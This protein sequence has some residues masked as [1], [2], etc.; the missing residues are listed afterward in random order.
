MAISCRSTPCLPG[1]TSRRRIDRHPAMGGLVRTRLPLSG[2]RITAGDDMALQTQH[3]CA[4]QADYPASGGG[5]RPLGIL[6]AALALTAGAISL[7]INVH[8]GWQTSVVAAAIFGLSDAAKILL[9]MAAAALGG[10]NIRRRMAW[11]VAVIISVAAALSSLLQSD[12]ERLHASRTAADTANAARIDDAHTRQQLAAITE[13]LSVEVLRQLADDAGA[14]AACEEASGGCGDRC[15][16]TQSPPQR[17]SGAAWPRRTTRCLAATTRGLVGQ[18]RCK[19]QSR[20]R[21]RGCSGGAHRRRQIPRRH[22]YQPRALHRDAHCSAAIGQSQRRCGNA[23]A[24]AGENA[25][26][27]G[28]ARAEFDH[29]Y[30]QAAEVGREPCL[31]SGAPGAWP[32]AACRSGPQRRAQRSSSLRRGRPA[33]CGSEAPEPILSQTDA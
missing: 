18:S 28:C 14:E 16:G 3:L 24:Q 26:Q 15:P 12:G 5:I 23:A 6:F 9:P 2:L 33:Q 1:L 17:L 30:H 21:R 25:N 13:I 4:R 8:F 19:S 32:S 11:L 10:W 7:M 31:L 22:H 27:A 29:A 20:T